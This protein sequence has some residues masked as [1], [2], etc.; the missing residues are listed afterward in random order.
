MKTHSASFYYSVSDF[1]F[2]H[3]LHNSENTLSGSRPKTAGSSVFDG[4]FSKM[5]LND[6]IRGKGVY[7]VKWNADKYSSGVYYYSIDFGDEVLTSK[8]L[9]IK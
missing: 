7:E 5:K 4:I 6:S 2:L 1:Y 9:L 8:M 3:N